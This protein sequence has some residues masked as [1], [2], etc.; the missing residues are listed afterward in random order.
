MVISR[1]DASVTRNFSLASGIQPGQ[2]PSQLKT[3]LGRPDAINGNTYTCSFEV[4]EKNSRPDLERLRKQ[5]L[6]LSDGDF[7]R[8][9]DYFDFSAYIE[10]NFVDSKLTYLAL[11]ESETYQF[12]P[13]SNC[14][15]KLAK[16]PSPSPTL[17]PTRSLDRAMVEAGLQ[18]HAFRF[19]HSDFRVSRFLADLLIYSPR[20]RVGASW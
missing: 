17:P 9:Y 2:T 10:A 16:S 11:W 7:H 8:N 3:I 18:T 15:L 13:S 14:S 1:G 12:F 19:S 5:C 6:R 4:Q 20:F